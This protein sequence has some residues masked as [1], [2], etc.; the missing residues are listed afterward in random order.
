MDFVV[1]LRLRALTLLLYTYDL[2][3][4]NKKY[5][6]FDLEWKRNK[7]GEEPD[8]NH[9]ASRPASFDATVP[10]RSFFLS[11]LLFFDSESIDGLKGFSW[12]SFLILSRTATLLPPVQTL[13]IEQLQREMSSLSLAFLPTPPPRSKHIQTNSH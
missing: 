6:R 2:S 5:S 9:D 11:L 7:S 13:R 4:T 8:Q 12:K 1:G 10:R 3:S